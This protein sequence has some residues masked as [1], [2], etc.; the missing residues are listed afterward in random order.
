MALFAPQHNLLSQNSPLN[1]DH[2]L[3]LDFDL[4]GAQKLW[5]LNLMLGSGLQMASRLLSGE[6]TLHQ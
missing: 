2:V 6:L 4:F 3:M 5:R 1:S